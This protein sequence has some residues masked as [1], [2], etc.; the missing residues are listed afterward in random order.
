MLRVLH[1]LMLSVLFLIRRRNIDRWTVLETDRNQGG[2][3]D[4]WIFWSV[5]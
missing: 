2:Y 5:N 1:L 3:S 4:H